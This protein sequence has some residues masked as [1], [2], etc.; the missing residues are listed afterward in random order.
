[1][2]S[3]LERL[4]VETILAG[5]HQL[6]VEHAALG[7]LLFQ[8]GDNFGEVAVERLFV[9]ALNEHL[10]AVAKDQ[11]A[12]AVPFWFKDPCFARRQLADAIGEHGEYGRVDREVHARMVSDLLS[13]VIPSA[14]R[15]L[16]R[17]RSLAEPALRSASDVGLGM[18][19][20]AMSLRASE[21]CSWDGKPVGQ[22]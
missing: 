13:L 6:G 3:E 5:Y 10:V 19:T 14:A 9:T 2:Q 20:T 17:P 4:E 7:E 1:M 21:K 11:R 12:E 8:R 22:R 18:T 15:D 16:G